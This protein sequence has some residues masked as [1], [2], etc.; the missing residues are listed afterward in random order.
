[1]FPSWVTMVVRSWDT[2]ATVLG[3]VRGLV[4]HAA[5]GIVVLMGLIHHGH[6]TCVWSVGTCPPR[7]RLDR[8][9]VGTYP[10]RSYDLCVVCWDLSATPPMESWSLWD[11]S[12]TPPTGSWSYEKKTPIPY[13]LYMNFFH[14]PM[15]CRSLGMATQKCLTSTYIHLQILFFQA[16][17]SQY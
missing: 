13:D 8:G 1:M 5:D 10:P 9:L 16:A 17:S 4:R 12:A 6:L 3:P 7:H 15:L 11:L 2:S 14:H